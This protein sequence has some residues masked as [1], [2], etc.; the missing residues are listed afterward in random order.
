MIVCFIITK[1]SSKIYFLLALYI[2]LC[3]IAALYFNDIAFFGFI[4]IIG[5]LPLILLLK[6]R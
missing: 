4:G 2:A 6:K 1:R 5:L 3:T